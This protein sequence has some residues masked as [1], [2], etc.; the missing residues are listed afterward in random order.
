MSSRRAFIALECN[1]GD[2]EYE[3]PGYVAP[4]QRK[5]THFGKEATSDGFAHDC[6]LVSVL[7]FTPRTGSTLLLAEISARP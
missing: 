4:A 7:P 6:F 5:E 3:R 1:D 2:D